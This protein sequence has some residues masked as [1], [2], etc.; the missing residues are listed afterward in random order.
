MKINNYYT[1]HDLDEKLHT[2]IDQSHLSR[3]ID[4]YMSDEKIVRMIRNEMQ[5]SGG[6]L[7]NLIHQRI[8]NY[9]QAHPHLQKPAPQEKQRPPRTKI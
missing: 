9:I 1:K 8:E 4:N 6:Y 7:S 3:E 5:D 2:K